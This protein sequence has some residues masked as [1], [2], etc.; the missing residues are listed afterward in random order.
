MGISYSAAMVVG[1]QKEELKD[2]EN[3]DDFMDGDLDAW[4]P[5]Y[6]GG[7]DAILGVPVAQSDDYSASEVTG[8]VDAKISAAK[9][10]FKEMTGMDGKV[11]ITTV[12]Y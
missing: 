11:W 3:F 7:S 9:E 5:Y 8:S 12:G 4:P 6:D 10:A 1:L 2:H